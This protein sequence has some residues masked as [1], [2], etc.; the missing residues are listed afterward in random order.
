MK[1]LA[2]EFFTYLEKLGGD[3]LQ[4]MFVHR[5]ILLC[6]KREFSEAYS[7]HTWEACWSQYRTSYFHLFI[8]VAIVTI[9]G[10][11]ILAQ[12]LPHDEILLYFAALAQHMN[13]D[14]VM[15]KVAY[16]QCMIHCMKD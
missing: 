6:F 11:D 4:L 5:W 7:L 13:P 2:P 10:P 12:E 1:L 15:Q 3:A 8:C 9:Y 14:V 16:I